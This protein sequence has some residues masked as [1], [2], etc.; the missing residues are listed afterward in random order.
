MAL[1]Q[2]PDSQ[3]SSGANHLK[4][5][6]KPSRSPDPY[7]ARIVTTEKS[8]QADQPDPPAWIPF[9]SN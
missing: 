1:A 4:R 7:A 8:I 2:N 5:F 3:I 6:K 9:P